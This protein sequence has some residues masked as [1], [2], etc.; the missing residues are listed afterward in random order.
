[1]WPD[2]LRFRPIGNDWP[3]EL[4]PS[5][6]RR[7]APFKSG[8]T[9][10]AELLDR[11]LRLVGAKAPVIQLALNE[12]QLRLDGLPRASAVP[13][14]PGV[15]VSFD[16]PRVGAVRY[17]TDHFTSW[18]DNLRAVALGLEAMRKL[19]RYGIV[20]DN[21]QY[22][23]WKAIESRMVEMTTAVAKQ[24]IVDLLPA[25]EVDW[26]DPDQVRL[27]CQHALR[28]SHPDYG[29]SPEVFQSVMA[30]RKV[31]RDAHINGVDGVSR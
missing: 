22:R 9:D 25:D 2:S 13:D 6:K 27:A 16:V 29:G 4:T 14:H 3:G 19:E 30:A 21:Q 26:T 11:E 7:Y 8:L 18:Q 20:R 15:I 31:L 5:S 17:P 10:T 12:S 28:L 23:G 1:M 24:V